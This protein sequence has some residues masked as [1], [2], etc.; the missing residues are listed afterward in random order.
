MIWGLSII[1][2]QKFDQAI[3]QYQKAIEINKNYPEPHINLGNLYRSLK[4]NEQAIQEYESALRIKP[5]LPE[6][7]QWLSA[8]YMERGQYEKAQEVLKPL[9]QKNAAPSAQNHVMQ[10]N[11]HQRQ[12]QHAQALA[13]YEKALQLNAAEPAYLLQHRAFPLLPEKLRGG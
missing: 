9:L 1:S 10:G 3:A 4:R 6:T 11:I 5:D 2:Q 8:L 7:R 12:G 13:E